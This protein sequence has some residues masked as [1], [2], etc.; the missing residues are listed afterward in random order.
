MEVHNNG[1]PTGIIYTTP[2]SPVHSA[3]ASLVHHGRQMTNLLINAPHKLAQLYDCVTLNPQDG[4][5]R[6]LFRDL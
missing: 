1:S 5:T 3:P 4:Y 6:S 2:S